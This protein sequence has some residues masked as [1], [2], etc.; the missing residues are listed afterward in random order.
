[1]ETKTTAIVAIIAVAAL[2]FAGVGYA[3]Y[4]GQTTVEDNAVTVEYIATQSEMEALDIDITFNTNYTAGGP[5][6][7]T[8]QSASFVTISEKNVTPVTFDKESGN[9]AV[10]CAY[11]DAIELKS[12]YTM[13]AGAYDFQVIISDITIGS[14]ATLYF[15]T[16]ATQAPTVANAF[17]LYQFY[18]T[19]AES[20]YVAQIAGPAISTADGAAYT[21]FAVPATEDYFGFI[22]LG[23]ADSSNVE[24][25]QVADVNTAAFS[26]NNGDIIIKAIVEKNEAEDAFKITET[27]SI[28]KSAASSVTYLTS[29]DMNGLK[30][31]VAASDEN[32]KTGE[33]TVTQAGAEVNASIAFTGSAVTGDHYLVVAFYDD[34]NSNGGMDAGEQV[35]Y[36]IYT[37]TYAA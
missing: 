26:I 23:E 29:A 6:T 1:M 20:T 28:S 37:A 4:W 3:A 34:L 30:I 11:G 25:V 5:F 24:G 14:N 15:A 2:A 13:T 19:E 10:G 12:P 22:F 7:I 27:P 9:L 21:N 32:L 18:P 35:F 17:T 31:A 33:F 16:A 8:P 36:R